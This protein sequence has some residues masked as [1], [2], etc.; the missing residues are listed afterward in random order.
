MQCIT[1]AAKLLT[2]SPSHPTLVLLVQYVFAQ[3]RYDASYD[4]RDR[5]R[6]LAALL[7]GLNLNLDHGE[8]VSEDDDP[9]VWERRGEDAGGVKL[10]IEQARVILFEGKAFDSRALGSSSGPYF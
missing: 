7:R 6:M 3:A 4:V 8:R 1:L 5:A 10:R 2:L 9:D